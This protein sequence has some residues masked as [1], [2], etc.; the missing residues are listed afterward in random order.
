MPSSASQTIITGV[1]VCNALL[2]TWQCI[3][4]LNADSFT[5]AKKNYQGQ[6]IQ[7]QLN[8]FSK[9]ANDALTLNRF[10]NYVLCIYGALALHLSGKY[11]GKVK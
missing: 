2:L 3:D 8:W 11:S 4:P 7:D 10:K 6:P 9:N 5:G 1:N